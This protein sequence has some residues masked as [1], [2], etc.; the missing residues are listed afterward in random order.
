LL[1]GAARAVVSTAK[2][3]ISLFLVA[4]ACSC[5]WW[6]LGVLTDRALSFM[7]GSKESKVE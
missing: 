5:G 4:I 7:Y 6:F 3:T 1:S 2:N